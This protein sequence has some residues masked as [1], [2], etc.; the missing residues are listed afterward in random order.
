MRV[1]KVPRWVGGLVVVLLLLGTL[2]WLS[3]RRQQRPDRLLV[4][5]VAD[6]QVY[7]NEAMVYWRLMQEE[8]ERLGSES[9]W[10]LEIL[11]ASPEQIALDRV[12]E[13]IVRIKVSQPLTRQLTE[14]EESK[15]QEK[16]QQLGNWLGADFM[17]MH[18]ID[19]ELLEQIVEENYK[20]YCYEQEVQFSA[21]SNEEEINQRLQEQFANYDYLDQE[22]YLSKAMIRTMMFYTGQ[23]VEDQWVT[24]SEAQKELIH[25]EAWRIKR[26][27]TAD[28]FVKTAK[29]YSDNWTMADNP[30]F[31]YG[32]VQHEQSDY[33]YVY[34][35]QMEPEVSEAVFNTGWGKVSNVLETDYG[36][37]IVYVMAFNDAQESDYIAYEEQLAA[38]KQE[39]RE[40]SIE[41]LKSQRLEEEWQRLETESDVQRFGAVL[42][43]YIAEHT[44]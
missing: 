6:Q 10:D 27:V 19:A 25:E 21:G 39:F 40:Q 11:G 42:S 38:A 41:E 30:V 26:M 44:V 28:N 13:S 12:L 18:A 1:K 2:I 8:F 34:R 15:V 22:Y 36:Y 4:L 35:G 37:L 14:Q 32:A 31:S 3:G 7:V 16:A 20:V 43:E 5:Q 24:Y 33:G 9:V 23:W 29:M 17:E